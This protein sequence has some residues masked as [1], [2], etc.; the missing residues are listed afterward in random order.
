V[1]PVVMVDRMDLS[2][3]ILADAE[4]AAKARAAAEGLSVA[5]AEHVAF[6]LGWTWGQ[7]IKW[8]LLN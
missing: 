4:R 8:A 7:R 1:I 5:M 3:Q 2:G 6:H